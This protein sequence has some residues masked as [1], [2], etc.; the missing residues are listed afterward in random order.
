MSCSSK[1][2]RHIGSC[3]STLVSSTNNLV[4]PVPPVF[5]ARRTG[6]TAVLAAGAASTGVLTGTL[7]GVCVKAAVCGFLLASAAT[8]LLRV[9]EAAGARGSVC[10]ALRW[11]RWEARAGASKSLAVRRSARLDGA[12]GNGMEWAR[13][14]WKVRNR[15]RK[16]EKAALS[17]GGFL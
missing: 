5:L 13:R 16:N 1:R 7:T 11:G 12:V 14:E 2:N 3:M 4:G 6:D 9:A 10:G 17:Q 8:G 15:S